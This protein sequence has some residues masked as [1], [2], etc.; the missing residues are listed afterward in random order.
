[1]GHKKRFRRCDINFQCLWMLL[2]LYI[3]DTICGA[4]CIYKM[5]YILY[6]DR[7]LF[8]VLT[9]MEMPFAPSHPR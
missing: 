4:G 1:V 2:D 3:V 5:D 7:L 8:V 9:K 6:I